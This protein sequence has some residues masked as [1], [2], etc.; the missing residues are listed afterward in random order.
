MRT[1]GSTGELTKALMRAKS[2]FPHIEKTKTATVP[3]K[4][5]PGY[6]YKYA[7]RGDIVPVI[8]PILR[9]ESLNVSQWPDHLDGRAALTTRLE[10]GESGEW[11]ES[12]FPLLE[13]ALPQAVGSLLTYFERYCYCAVLGIVADEDDD[14]ASAQ[15]G[16]KNASESHPRARGQG[17]GESRRPTPSPAAAPPSRSQNNDRDQYAWS[18]GGKVPTP[19]E[20]AKKAS[21]AQIKRLFAIAKSASISVENALCDLWSVDQ[22]VNELDWRQYKFLTEAI[23]D[24]WKPAE[25]MV[26]GVPWDEDDG[27]GTGQFAYDD[28]PF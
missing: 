19:D 1:S 15:H 23:E 20:R 3:T 26:D 11:Q 14:G 28:E 8:D 12:T 10:H 27:P 5:G 18:Q 22:D 7:D 24:G 17:G 6:S 16:H 21:P 2:N 4:T 13:A 25:A 9:A